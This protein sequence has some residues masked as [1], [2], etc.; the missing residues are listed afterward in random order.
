MIKRVIPDIV[1]ACAFALLAATSL[2][3]CSDDVSPGKDASAAPVIA[4]GGVDSMVS[5]PDGGVDTTVGGGL[6]LGA[7]DTAGCQGTCDLGSPSIDIAANADTGADATMD[8]AADA[9]PQGSPD[10]AAEASAATD[11]SADLDTSVCMRVCALVAMVDCPG[12][13]PCLP[14]CMVSLQ[15]KCAGVGY[16][17]QTCAAARP[18]TDFS[19]RSVGPMKQVALR[20]DVCADEQAPLVR[21]FIT[22]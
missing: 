4:E 15:G 9:P 16:A 6:D 5:L 18:A 20:A 2:A 1:S 14:G 12:A 17:L 8:L 13:M 21:C 22:P 19:C 10:A 7:E 3:A 11:V